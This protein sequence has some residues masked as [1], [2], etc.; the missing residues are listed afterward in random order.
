LCDKFNIPYFVDK[1]NVDESVSKRNK[2][3][4]IIFELASLANVTKD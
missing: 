4:K 3:R 1:T 2:I